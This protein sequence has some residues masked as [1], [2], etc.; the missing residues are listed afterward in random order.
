[1]K[2]DYFD[3]I[4]KQVKEEIDFLDKEIQEIL[5]SPHALLFNKVFKC[6]IINDGKVID[7]MKIFTKECKFKDLIYGI[8]LYVRTIDLIDY[9]MENPLRI[10]GLLR[11]INILTSDYIFISFNRVPFLLDDKYR[12]QY[13]LN[14]ETTLTVLKKSIYNQPLLVRNQSSDVY[15]MITDPSIFEDK[16]ALVVNLKD[17]KVETREV[18][19]CLDTYTLVDKNNNE[20]LSAKNLKELV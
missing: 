12:L 3:K 14:E 17:R 8:K 19:F 7:G 13:V 1:M 5:N 4:L 9:Y 16:S 18:F 2:E 20:I 15:K 6:T 11:S 10:K